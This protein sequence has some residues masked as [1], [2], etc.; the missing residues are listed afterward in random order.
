MKKKGQGMPLNVIIIAIIVL[1]VLVILISLVTGK[2]GLFSKGVVDSGK[3]NCES[4]SYDSAFDA[5]KINDCEIPVS[6]EECKDYNE[7]T[8]EGRF[9]CLK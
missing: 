7:N 6:A 8:Q 5:K 4:T 2:L 3:F 1:I 9:R